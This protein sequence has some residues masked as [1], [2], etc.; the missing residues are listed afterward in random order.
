MIAWFPKFAFIW[1][2]L[3]HR[4]TEVAFALL[5]TKLAKKED[6]IYIFANI[7]PTPTS[8]LEEGDTVLAKYKVECDKLGLE[9]ELHAKHDAST[10]VSEDI[11]AFAAA[12]GCIHS[13]ETVL[14][15]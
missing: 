1:V 3:Y 6:K 13:L 9:C 7:P 12:G 5:V 4:Y 14:P 15:I 8:H 10:N 2:N 11:L